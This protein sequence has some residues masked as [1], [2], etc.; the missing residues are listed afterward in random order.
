MKKYGMVLLTMLVLSIAP[1]AAQAI[2]I[3]GDF[4]DWSGI[5]VLTT[6]AAFPTSGEPGAADTVDWT[7][8]KADHDGVNFH[9]NYTTLNNVDFG[10]NAHRYVILLDTD[11]NVTTG[12]DWTGAG[13]V[14]VEYMVQGATLF[15]HAGGG[16]NWTNLGMQTYGVTSK[17]AEIA[18]TRA[19]LGS[20]T[21]YDV[22]FYGDNASI[23]D[24]TTKSTYTIP[25]PSS[26]LLLGSGLL[27][28]VA[29]AVKK[30]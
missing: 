20:P 15:Q 7:E 12:F 3:D 25:E 22:V 21:S 8:V 17:K 5:S 14:G 27:G 6:D 19:S 24:W 10:S 26:F 9:F 16:W 4:T 2:V 29:F 30:K 18:I 28:L 13:I 11:R 23:A 1:S